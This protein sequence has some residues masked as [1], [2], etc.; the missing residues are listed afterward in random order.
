MPETR[1]ER[2]LF[3]LGLV[4]SALLALVI[5]LDWDRAH[6]APRPRA[7]R[8]TTQA[9][10][11]PRAS[12]PTTTAPAPPETT[13]V[14]ST[15]PRAKA[16]TRVTLTVTAAR[17]ESWIEVRS[18]SATAAVVYG[19]TLPSGSAKTFR[20]RELFVRFGQA[21]NVDATIDGKRRRL[22]GGTYTARFNP[23]GYAFVHS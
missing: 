21:G 14:A 23:Q 13:T 8:T 11:D 6:T 4:A 12:V 1:V 16:P 18:G 17:G 20:A 7:S 10:S 9:L 15:T 22:P 19:G 2:V 5:V 3:A